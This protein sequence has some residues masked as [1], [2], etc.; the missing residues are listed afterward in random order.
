[1]ICLSTDASK[2]G[3]CKLLTYKS[4]NFMMYQVIMV[5][6]VLNLLRLSCRRSEGWEQMPDRPVSFGFQGQH[7]TQRCHMPSKTAAGH[8]Q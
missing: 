5:L 6:Y 3:F 4:S 8:R 7:H 2:V 1:M